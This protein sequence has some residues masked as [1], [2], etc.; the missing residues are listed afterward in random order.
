M[1]G[2]FTPQQVYSLPS[3]DSSSQ[4]VVTKRVAFPADE[5]VEPSMVVTMELRETLTGR[6]IGR[7]RVTIEEDSDLKKPVIHW[8]T[9]VIHVTGFDSRTERTFTFERN[10]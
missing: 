3:P 4:I 10:G 2:G 7:K 5:Y 6:V 8:T 9:D 1:D